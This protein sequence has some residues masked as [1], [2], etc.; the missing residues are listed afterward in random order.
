MLLISLEAT[1]IG[2]KIADEAELARDGRGL[3]TDGIETG[4]EVGI[5]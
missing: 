3:D 5:T 1:E 2:L 4:T